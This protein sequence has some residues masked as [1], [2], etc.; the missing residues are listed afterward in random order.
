MSKDFIRYY[1]GNIHLS[2]LEA[3]QRKSGKFNEWKL[4][5]DSEFDYKQSYG[6][7]ENFIRD[8]PLL[9]ALAKR[10]VIAE[11]RQPE[12][13]KPSILWPKA[14]NIADA[15]T[16]VSLASARHYS[17][18][19][20][21][22]KLGT[23]Y[24]ITWGLIPRDVAGNWNNIVSISNFGRFI[25]EALTFLED[26]PGW[27]EDSG[28]I[29]SFYWYEQAQRSEFTAPSILEMGLYWVSLEVLANTYI[30][31][32]G[33]NI[34]HKKRRVECFVTDRGYTGSTWD[35]LGEAIND[36]YTAR[37][38]LFHEGTEKL[39]I[40]LLAKRGKQIRDFTSLVFV[41]MLQ[42]QDD[43]RKNKIATQ[44]QNY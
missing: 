19:A 8:E 36:W 6:Y 43:A 17:I 27:L 37:N 29:P 41:E 34:P 5:E 23:S 3:V 20:I 11:T 25:S 18:L 12:S 32:Q 9:E 44:I 39:P 33:I 14:S 2:M 7:E 10:S 30:E 31:T 40:E 26:N 28:F 22:K 38:D 35:F 4:L 21:E 15:L 42:K 13:V 24:G 1:I 16:L